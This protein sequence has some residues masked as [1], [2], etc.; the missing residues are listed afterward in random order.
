MVEAAPPTLS[1]FAI[2]LTLPALPSELV[3][4]STDPPFEI[5]TD[6]VLA[7]D[8]CPAF[9]S[10]APGARV[11]EPEELEMNEPATLND[12]ATMDT[13][14]ALPG[15]RVSLVMAAPFDKVT[16]PL[17]VTETSPTLPVESSPNLRIDPPSMFND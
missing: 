16:G 3:T 9:P 11:A 17:V 12:P 6:P 4:D 2:T 14:P 15:K 13:L 8:T 7:T 10:G 1:D 5:V